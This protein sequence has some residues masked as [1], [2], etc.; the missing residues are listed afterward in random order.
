MLVFALGEHFT[1]DLW[2]EIQ[3]I[4]KAVLP[5]SLALIR[6]CCHDNLPDC[7]T[8]LPVNKELNLVSRCPLWGCLHTPDATRSTA[9]C[10]AFPQPVLETWEINNRGKRKGGNLNENERQFAA[11]H[12]QVHSGI[13]DKHRK[14]ITAREESFSGVFIFHVSKAYRSF[15]SL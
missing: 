2:M 12:K 13:H 14:L 10:G 4:S 7:W 15:I 1:G 5:Q 9:V 11:L 3:E 6:K 8:S